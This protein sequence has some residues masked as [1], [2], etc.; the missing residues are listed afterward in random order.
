LPQFLFV[1][2]IPEPGLSTSNIDGPIK[3]FDFAKKI[4][5]ISL[6]KG[7][8]KLP[9]KNVWLFPAEGSEQVRRALAN[10]AD[11][12]QLCHSTFLVSGD[13]TKI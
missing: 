9:C 5:S 3:W 2:D 8:M 11:D 13:V 10:S 7:A 6:P 4:E 1:V 12:H